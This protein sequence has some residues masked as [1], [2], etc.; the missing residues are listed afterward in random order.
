MVLTKSAE[1]RSTF[2]VVFLLVWLLLTAQGG[3][4]PE[5]WGTRP[6]Y[7]PR[8]DENAMDKLKSIGPEQAREALLF[9]DD[10]GYFDSGERYYF[11]EDFLILERFIYNQKWLEEFDSDIERVKKKKG[12]D[13]SSKLKPHPR[14]EQ[15][16]NNPL[17][18][19]VGMYTRC[20]PGRDTWA[21]TRAP[22]VLIGPFETCT[23]ML[24]P[25]E[26]IS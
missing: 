5:N 12:T 10:C 8:V 7:L 11:F 16:L 2:A 26:I 20:R 13:V 15:L 3:P 22:L 21:V 1:S 4:R 18:P 9:L 6:D 14:R 23:G 19:E 24:W 25:W 17:G